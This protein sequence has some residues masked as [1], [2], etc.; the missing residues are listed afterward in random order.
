MEMWVQIA[1]IV[2]ACAAILA[3]II[4]VGIYH[5]GLKREKQLETLKVFS[6]IRKK[7][8]N[9]VTLDNHEKLQYL[10]ELEYFSTGVNLGIYDIKVVKKMSRRRLLGQYNTWMKDFIYARR[11]HGAQSSSAYC[12]VEKMINEIKKDYFLSKLKEY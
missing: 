9:T 4:T 1:T 8:F 12:E 5:H 6:D 3:L 11:D 2:S 10:N 7:Y